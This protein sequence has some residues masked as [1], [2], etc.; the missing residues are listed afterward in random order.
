MAWV[1]PTALGNHVSWGSGVYLAG[2]DRAA[3]GK[4]AGV[5][6]Q[7]RP[8]LLRGRVSVLALPSFQSGHTLEHSP[9]RVCR[10]VW[11]VPAGVLT[12]SPAAKILQGP[13]TGLAPNSSLTSTMTPLLEPSPLYRCPQTPA[14]EAVS[15]RPLARG[16]G[17][18]SQVNGRHQAPSGQ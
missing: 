7:I 6:G 18:L 15:D 5:G 4:G 3:L 9:G 16:T 11:P 14:R 13:P 8:L 10:S 2:A 17:R 12:L 1:L